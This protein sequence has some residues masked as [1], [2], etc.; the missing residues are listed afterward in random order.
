MRDHSSDEENVILL[1][2]LIANWEDE[3]IE[4]K[5]A[6][7]NFKTDEIGR[8]VSALSNEVNLAGIESAW[9]V[10]G[11]RDR[12]HEVVGTSYRMEP[13]RL[14]SLK[15]QVFEGAVP[16]FGLRDI[17]VIG[18]PKG[19]RDLVRDSCCTPGHAHPMEGLLLFACRREPRARAD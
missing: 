4:F 16:N 14:S 18:H 3:T 13:K 12:D 9:L 7:D 10:F 2:E 8:Y 6:N 15:R 11:V 17:R 19:T 1:E 5:E